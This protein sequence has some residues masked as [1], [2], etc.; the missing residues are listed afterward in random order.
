M[1]RDGSKSKFLHRRKSIIFFEIKYQ[2]LEFDEWNEGGAD[3]NG[4][5]T[6][7]TWNTQ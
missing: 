5:E 1:S 6:D 7:S 2:F 4:S 3:G